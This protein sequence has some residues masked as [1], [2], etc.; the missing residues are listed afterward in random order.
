MIIFVSQWEVESKF[1]KFAELNK[2][3]V[4]TIS[5]QMSTIFPS[6]IRRHSFTSGT[7][8]TDKQQEERRVTLNLWLR[9]VLANF[10][11]LP[12]E[13]KKKVVTFVNIPKYMQ[14]L[15]V[16]SDQLDVFEQQRVPYLEPAAVNILP[17]SLESALSF[18]NIT[19]DLNGQLQVPGQGQG[20]GHSPATTSSGLNLPADREKFNFLFDSSTKRSRFEKFVRLLIGYIYAMR[21][22]WRGEQPLRATQL[23]AASKCVCVCRSDRIIDFSSQSLHLHLVKEIH[24]SGLDT[25][26]LIVL[27]IFL[28]SGTSYQIIWLRIWVVSALYLA[29]LLYRDEEE[30]IFRLGDRNSSPRGFKRYVNEDSDFNTVFT[31]H[32]TTET[33]LRE[34]LHDP[35]LTYEDNYSYPAVLEPGR[36]DR[37]LGG[38]GARVSAPPQSLGPAEGDDIFPAGP[39]E[40]SDELRRQK[41][42]FYSFAFDDISDGERAFSLDKRLSHTFQVIKMPVILVS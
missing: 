21:S 29:Y 19:A 9:E 8:L 4:S 20:Q 39:A 33:V 27:V 1:S 36:R 35:D 3:I 2:H 16:S 18:E 25:Y 17:N 10:D 37:D 11:F 24:R 7:K 26:M 32:R 40:E 42:V 12:L 6:A 34:Y 30:N 28:Q 5:H 13:A 15:L 14:I 31:A 22:K 38:R 41:E 23:F